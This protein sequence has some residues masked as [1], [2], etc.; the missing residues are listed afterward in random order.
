MNQNRMQ[1]PL[2]LGFTIL[3]LILHLLLLYLVPGLS[4][5][6]K[7]KESPDRV[8]VTMVPSKERLERELDLTPDPD[9]VKP[10]DTPAKRLAEA[11]Q[12]V[13]QE[14]APEGD[15]FEDTRPDA[16]AQASED[17]KT[18][19]VAR[20]AEVEAGSETAVALLKE[21]NK[22]TAK[23]ES[24]ALPE[25]T[26]PNLSPEAFLTLPEATKTRMAK[27]WRQKYR[28]D[29]EKGDAVWLDTEQDLLFS[30]FERL[31]A[32]IYNV[33]NYPG[34]SARR[35]EA[36][37]CLLRF[38]L[39]RRGE[40]LENPDVLESS[41]FPR[42]DKE[43]VAA[44]RKGAPYGP[45]PRTYEKESLTIMAFFRYDLRRSSMRRPGDIFGPQ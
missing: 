30:V 22:P 24:A 28:E 25:T 38:T 35:G 21:S 4:L 10:R 26:L 5:F 23:P 11:N 32:N 36:G 18:A 37:T 45:L 44:V 1:N 16:P 15:A 34:E 27:D 33:W 14:Q 43:A 39:N 3:S 6:P 20:Q 8:V 31:R 41:G 9:L 13:K 42:L 17:P 2:L 19:I 7:A 40:L 12:V 29:V